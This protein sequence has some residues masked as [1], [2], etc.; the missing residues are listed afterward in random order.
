MKVLNSLCAFRVKLLNAPTD[1]CLAWVNSVTHCTFFATAGVV[2]IISVLPFDHF[3]LMDLMY[4]IYAN[5]CVKWTIFLWNRN[6]LTCTSGWCWETIHV[7]N[8]RHVNNS[9]RIAWN[10]R[11][12][13]MW[14]LFSQWTDYFR[15]SVHLCVLVLG[16]ASSSAGI[17][18]WFSFLSALLK[19]HITILY[20][21]KV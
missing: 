17:C 16:R 20:W 18:Q 4:S 15:M 3:H 2:A 21:R 11:K 9:S 1:N 10:S 13:V 7:V 8:L 12:F 19:D 5:Q 14:P 6:R